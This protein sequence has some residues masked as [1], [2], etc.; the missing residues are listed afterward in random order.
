MRNYP[1][2]GVQVPEIYLPIE[3]IDRT[4]W[5]VIACD[6]YTSQPEYWEQVAKNV[7]DCPSTF[8]LILPEVYLGTTKETERVQSTH[9]K[10][11]QYL[12]DGLLKSQQNVIYVERTV[13]KKTRRGLMLALDLEHYD[14]SKGSQSLIRATEGT[15]LD[16]IPP[17]IRI[18]KNAPLE[19]PHIVVLIDDPQDMVIG[20]VTQA[21]QRLPLASVFD[22][23][24][25]GGHLRGR[26]VNDSALEKSIIQNLAAL[27]DPQTFYAKYRV[28]PDKGV[29]L[30]A[31]GD[32]N[33]SLA[34]AKAIWEE[35][36]SSVSMDH[37]AR[38]ALVEVENIH[39]TGL[40]FEPIHRVLFNSKFN[41]E[42]V[43]KG[44]FDGAL[45]L[46][47]VGSFS[48]LSTK[49]KQPSVECQRFGL[50]STRGLVVAS[51]TSPTANLVVGTLQPILDRLVADGSVTS[52]D[53]VHGDEALCEL[54]MKPANTGI[55]LPGMSKDEL[56]RTVMLDGALPRKTFSMGEAHEKRFYMESRKITI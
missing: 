50:V 5:A 7:G 29:L 49:V 2:I 51:I 33:H 27:A 3:K 38:F 31:V 6:Q 14:F 28:S 48:E 43:L 17:R 8:H 54:G 30:F 45:T 36:K 52:I 19:L 24:Q 13:G 40:A 21:S 16:R 23:M 55:Y 34:T 35:L 32:G 53:Y 39:D 10:M 1:E 18:R 22:L 11:Q 41:L 20:P 37:P 47:P 12:S 42:Q 15:I 4:K 9:A 56:F 26:L 25:R 44:I 46:E